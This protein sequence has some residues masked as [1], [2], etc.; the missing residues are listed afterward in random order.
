MTPLDWLLIAYAGVFVINVVP[1][2]MP[3]TWMVVAFFLI[4]YRLPLWPLCIGCAVAATGGRCV[5][6][7]ISRRWGR[8][9]LSAKQQANVTALGNWLNGKSGW[10][11]M[12]AVLLYASGPIPSNQ[13]FIAA[14]LSNVKIGPIAAGFFLGRMVS[15]PFFATTARGVNDRFGNIFIKEWKDP[16]F[17]VLELLSVA[18]VVIFARIDWPRLLHLPVPSVKT[19][20]SASPHRAPTSGP[21]VADSPPTSM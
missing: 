20:D 10:R 19:S 1:A 17:I 9:L 13:M 12:L 16:K 5:L 7:L 11:Q 14:G 8:K 3:A 21:A 6:T 18:G 2:F 4:V 15:Y